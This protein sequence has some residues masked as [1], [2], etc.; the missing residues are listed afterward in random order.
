MTQSV[1]P[2]M[3]PLKTCYIKV[4]VT[5]VT[6]TF[7]GTKS[8]SKVRC[9]KLEAMGNTH[10]ARTSDLTQSAKQ[11]FDKALTASAIQGNIVR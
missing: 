5:S 1:W 7:T 9:N 11:S 4:R 8:A 2:H 3:R 10:A 6:C